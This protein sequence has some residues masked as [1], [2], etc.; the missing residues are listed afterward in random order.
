MLSYF[1]FFFQAEDGIRD[2]GLDWSSDV[3]SSDLFAF[4]I[5]DDGA[6]VYTSCKMV[7]DMSGFP[8]YFYKM[9][10]GYFP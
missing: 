9:F 7:E 3:C 4:P 8:E 1:F 6:F 2:Q 10:F 5:G